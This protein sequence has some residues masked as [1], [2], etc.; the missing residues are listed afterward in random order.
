MKI[1]RLLTVSVVAIGLLGSSGGYAGEI[2]DRTKLKNDVIRMFATKK[3]AELETISENFRS[4]K[5]RTASGLWQLTIFQE[6]LSWAFRGKPEDEAG[7]Q[8]KY[9]R[10]RSWVAA[11]PDSTTSHLA[12][13][14]L[15]L[16]HAWSY[17]G[18]GNANSVN[19][20]NRKSFEI[21]VE[22]AREYLE[23]TKDITSRDPNWY[24]M[25]VSIARF[26]N[27]PEAAFIKLTAEAFAR[28][29]HF[30]Q[31][32]FTAM[33]Y[34]APGWGGSHKALDQFIRE[35]QQDTEATEGYA[36]YARLYWYAAQTQ[37][38]ENLFTHSLVDWE[39]M[40][41]G[42]DDVLDDYTE[43]WN[44]HNF[45]KFSCL[46]GD[47]QKA[48]ELFTFIKDPPVQMAWGN[49]SFFNQC[50]AWVATKTPTLLEHFRNFLMAVA[51]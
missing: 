46:A 12:Y 49:Q 42:I 30:Y 15:L 20:E 29:P 39:M 10:M 8:R 47:I 36:M 41:K 43:S 17:R 3:F 25:M 35:V 37:Y 33:S 24:D 19:N 9:Q 4:T 31:T 44:I 6:G 28:E 1:S 48:S 16:S 2:E 27:W 11:H 40:K 22:Q 18:S 32:Y 14:Q 38:G 5:A 51:K 26:Q 23:A 7:W 45:A 50:R 13:A 34:Y 21:Y